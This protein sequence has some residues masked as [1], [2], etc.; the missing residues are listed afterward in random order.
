[1][2]ILVNG[3]FDI[4]HRGH[5]EMLNYAKSLGDCLVVC[6]DSDR[7]V[8]ELKGNHRPINNQQDRE[9]YLKNLAAVDQVWIFDSAAQL[10]DMCEHYQPDIMVKGSDYRDQPIIGAEY[11]KEIRF[12]DRVQ[13]YSTTKTIE[14]INNRK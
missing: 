7:R 13:Q 8:S 12:F 5:I 4:L 3:T 6:I 10:E 2:K 1:M 14:N 9:F 11:C